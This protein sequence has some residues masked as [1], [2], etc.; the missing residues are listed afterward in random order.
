MQTPS[1]GPI[2][3]LEVHRES[4]GVH[5]RYLV[6]ALS[7]KAMEAMPSEFHVRLTRMLKTS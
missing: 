4:S 3:V 1:G 6:S 7:N 5:G 2:I